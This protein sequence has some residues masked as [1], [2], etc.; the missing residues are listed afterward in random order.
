MLIKIISATD[1]RVIEG[2]D[3]RFFV[4]DYGDAV[5]DID[6]KEFIVPI[7]AY[8]MNDAGDTVDKFDPKTGRK[9]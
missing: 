1:T 4:D 3:V 6:G 2:K 5:A 9:P 7:K 8:V